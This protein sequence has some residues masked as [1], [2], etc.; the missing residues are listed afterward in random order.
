MDFRVSE[1]TRWNN[2]FQ[3]LLERLQSEISL[4]KDVKADAN[5][6]L[7]N[8]N[9]HLK[10]TAQCISLRDCRRGTELTYDEGDAELKKELAV[11]ENLKKRLTNRYLKKTKKII[12]GNVR[13]MC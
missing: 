7:D 6:E 10:L 3:S 4:F 12:T 9:N 11:L 2:L 1:L 5:K 8:L 13:S